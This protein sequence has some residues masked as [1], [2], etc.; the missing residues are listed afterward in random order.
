MLKRTILFIGLV[1]GGFGLTAQSSFK[2]GTLTYKV[3]NVES[4]DMRLNLLQGLIVLIHFTP[5]Q[6][7]T[8]TQALFGALSQKIL[9]DKNAG[10]VESFTSAFGKNYLVTYEDGGKK[11]KEGEKD[12]EVKEVKTDIKYYPEQKRKIAGYPTYKAVITNTSEDKE[13][14]MEVYIAESLKLDV[15]LL[16]DFKGLDKLKGLPLEYTL[17]TPKLKM[18]FTAT[19]VKKELDTAIFK[20]DRSGYEELSPEEMREKNVFGF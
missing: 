7:L 1:I 20:I 3:T 9:R 12:K 18:T 5:Q 14:K 17:Q 2:E 11:G 4:D 19:A 8:T 15:E 13:V 6:Q 16:R 10:T